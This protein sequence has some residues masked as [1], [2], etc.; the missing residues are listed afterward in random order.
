[1]LM[2][3]KQYASYAKAGLRVTIKGLC[4]TLIDK[5]MS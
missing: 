5:L 4:M 3:Y 2:V 1:M